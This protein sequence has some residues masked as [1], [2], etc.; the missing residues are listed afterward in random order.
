MATGGTPQTVVLATSFGDIIIAL[1]ITHSPITV[2]NFLSYANDRFYDSTIFHRVIPGFMIQGG[3][4]NANMTIK[5][6]QTPIRNEAS[7]GLSNLRGTIAMARTSDPNSA[8]SQFFINVVDNTFLDYSATNAGYAV[9][10]RVVEGMDVVDRIAA[11]TTGNSGAYQDVPV[12]TIAIRTVLAA[13]AGLDLDRSDDSGASSSDNIT[14]N[15]SDLTISGIGQKGATVTLF[16]DQNNDGIV[17]DGESFGTT[18]VSAS[19]G[20]WSKDV[21]LSAGTHTLRTL[22]KSNTATSSVSEAL[23]VVVDE[24]Q[25]AIAPTIGRVSI[26]AD[27]SEGNNASGYPSLSADGRLVAFVSDASNLV[28][29]DSNGTADVFVY[30]NSSH[31]TSRVSVGI[32]GVQ[33]NGNSSLPSISADGRWVAFGSYASNLVSGDSNGMRD[34]FVYDTTLRQTSRVSVANGGGQSNGHSWQLSISSD[35]HFVAFDSDASNLVSGDSNGNRDVFVYDTTLRQTSR[36]SVASDGGQSNDV[37]YFPSISADGRWVAFLSRASNLVSGDDNGVWDVFVHDRTLG[38]TSRVSI[39]SDAVQG[40]GDSTYP[41]ISDDGRFVAFMSSADNL[42]ANDSN[43]KQ[44]VFVHDRTLNQTIRVSVANDGSQG[45]DGSG[46]PSISADGRF[47][48]FTSYANN[49]V[50]GDDNDAADIFIH[51]VSLKQTVRV[52]VASNGAQGRYD[53]LNSFISDDG[54]LVAFASYAD[55]LV[56]GGANNVPDIFLVALD[57]DNTTTTPTG[58]ASPSALDLAVVDD[59]GASSSDNITGKI[60]LT[61]TGTGEVGAKITLFDGSSNKGTATVTAAGSWSVKVSGLSQGNHSFTAKQA[62]AGQLSDAS[63]PLD[64]VIDTTAPSAPS[65]LDLADQSDLGLSATDNITSVTESLSISGRGEAGATVVLFADKNKN[66]RWDSGELK[67]TPPLGDTDGLTG[68][69]VGAEGGWSGVFTALPAGNHTIV[70]TQADVAGNVS[71]AAPALLLTIDTTPPAAPTKLDLAAEDD[72]GSSSSDHTTGVTENL[73]I[74]GAGE[75]GARIYL[76]EGD[77]VDIGS[78]LATATVG[79][80]GQ[81]STDVALAVGDHTLKAVQS[82][83]AGNLSPVSA[84]LNLNIYEAV[85]PEAPAVLALLASDD[86]GVVGDALTSKSKGLTITGTGIPGAKVV[87][88][89][90]S[91]VAKAIGTATVTTTGSWNVKVASLTVGPHP[92]TAKQTLNGETSQ[93]SEPLLLSVDNSVPAAPSGI[94]LN[95]DTKTNVTLLTGTGVAIAGSGSEG[96]TVTLFDDVNK[97]SKMD[98]G[99]QLVTAEPIVVADGL[100]TTHTGLTGGSHAIRAFQTSLAGTVGKVSTALTVTVQTPGS[101]DL[102]TDD[103]TGL[104]KSDNITNKSSGLTLSGTVFSG[105]RSVTLFVD[106][107]PSATVVASKGLWKTDLSLNHKEAPYAI[108]ATQINTDGSVSEPSTPFYLTVDQLAPE[109]APVVTAVVGGTLLDDGGYI[110]NRTTNL[111]VT[112]SSAEPGAAVT[113]IENNKAIGTGFADGQGNWSVTFARVAN[114]GHTVKVQQ[115][116][117]AGNIGPISTE[118]YV[119]TVDSIAPAAPTGL[120]ATGNVVTGKGEKGASLTL[121]ND[122]NNDGKLNAGELIG[123]PLLVDAATGNW[124]TAVDLPAG[125]YPRIKAV[126]SDLAG[127]VSRVSA[128]VSVT[129]AAASLSRALQ[130]GYGDN[131]IASLLSPLTPQPPLPQ[132]QLTG[133]PF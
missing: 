6:T 11:V 114:G 80:N 132:I 100:W 53:S 26:A 34:V 83:L 95:G 25:S 75:K 13:P 84:A 39:S 15:S 72:S 40:N 89:E 111:V 12:S 14:G 109:T 54:R 90:G 76:F 46:L 31:R 64:V 96:A 127:N 125:K 92:L 69:V 61:V 101:F 130:Q 121:F 41:S 82:D 63:E 81:W 66:G 30:D 124:S 3:G 70:A 60:G 128:A 59:S 29:G 94:Q 42:V 88:S 28:S 119:C 37:S 129:I 44:D 51:D 43:S 78:A 20:K 18:A 36:I 9:F 57:V 67:A 131:R 102:A 32:G 133:T 48:T 73:T 7:N 45:S 126:Q 1:D 77:E 120:K 123:E 23:L 22:Q 47:V 16:D 93:A 115:A 112:G 113:L 74:T 117:L 52:N 21:A 38:Q 86:T 116:D 118:S 56:A 71:K 50:S 55:N 19:T 5:P 17:D 79:N 110:T 58:I 122:S 103:D 35:G 108:T 87:L 104:S 65:G 4:F 68:I 62:I 27:G 85:L 97:N 105:G 91:G 8:T 107:E 49:L 98:A 10:G 33:G 24:A 99:E 2:A 106:G